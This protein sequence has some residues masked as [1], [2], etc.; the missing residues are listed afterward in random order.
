MEGCFLGLN[1]TIKKFPFHL[2]YFGYVFDV[3]SAFIFI[4]TQTIESKPQPVL[5]LHSEGRKH[6]LKAGNSLNKIPLKLLR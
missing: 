2:D 6:V 5:Q 1:I 4:F 3:K